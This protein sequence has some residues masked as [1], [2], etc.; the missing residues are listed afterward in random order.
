MEHPISYQEILARHGFSFSKGLGQ[1][2]LTNPAI[3]ARIAEG[4]GADENT[5]VLEVGPGAGILTRELARIAHHVTALE[6]DQRLL[7]VLDETL[8][9][10]PN[11]EVILQDIMEADIPALV[12]EKAKGY[13]VVAAA[14]LPYYIT[15]PVLSRLL[16]TK[17]FSSVTV[18]VQKEVARRLV[19]KPGTPDYGAFSVFVQY[20]AKPKILFD[21]PAGCFTPRPK[22][23]SAV[24][25]MDAYNVPPVAVPSDKAFF[26]T[27]HA[28]FSMRR[29]TLRNCILSAYGNKLTKDEISRAFETS[30]INPE[31]RGESL[32]LEEFAALSTALNNI[33]KDPD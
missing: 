3:P 22:V 27:V 9:D 26:D 1:N 32:S 2:F 24:V 4:C 10:R 5:F 21:V 29:K 11:A 25:R 20:Y 33:K 7:P 18:M 28:A 31:R 12:A 23:D 17:L 15:S 30:A 19:A 16:E 6:I 13:K 8:A 14:N